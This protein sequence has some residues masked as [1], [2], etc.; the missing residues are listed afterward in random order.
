[1]SKGRVFNFFSVL[2]I[3][4]LCLTAY[5][6]ESQ[7]KTDQVLENLV[8]E[9]SSTLM[10][11]DAAEVSSDDSFDDFD[12]FDVTGDLSDIEAHS[13]TIEDNWGSFNRKMFGFNDKVYTHVIKPSNKGYNYVVPEKGA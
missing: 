10:E 9:E 4:M 11:V 2:I 13:V 6:D 3:S 8:K 12:D 5:A 1:M 7:S